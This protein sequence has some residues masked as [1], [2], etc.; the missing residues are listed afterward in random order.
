MTQPLDLRAGAA[1]LGLDPKPEVMEALESDLAAELASI[2]LYP[3]VPDVL[4]GLHERGI[5]VAVASS[6]AKPYAAPLL[7]RLPVEPDAYA[8]S[9]E[10]GYLKPDRRIFFWTCE[11]LSAPP[12][13]ALMIGDSLRADYQGARAAGMQA[14]HLRRQKE[15]GNEG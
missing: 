9:F 5:K 7:A 12:E 6:L 4:A 11:R 14:I 8:W 10:V 15:E 1:A 3:K 2:E 13:N